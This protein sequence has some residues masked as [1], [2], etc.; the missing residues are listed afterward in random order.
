MKTLNRVLRGGVL[1]TALA[2]VAV[3]VLAA[4]GSAALTVDAIIPVIAATGAAGGLVSSVRYGTVRLAVG[5][6]ALRRRPSRRPPRHG[7]S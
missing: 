1:L 4:G 2:A 5:R 3:L 7:G 6:T